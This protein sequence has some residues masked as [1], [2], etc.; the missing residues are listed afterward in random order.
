MI[1]DLIP[2]TDQLLKWIGSAFAWLVSV[3]DRFPPAET[4]MKYTY[5]FHAGTDF[6]LC[7]ASLWLTFYTARARRRNIAVISAIFFVNGMIMVLLS[8]GAGTS[9]Y[10]PISQS[11]PYIANLRNFEW[12]LKMIAVATTVKLVRVAMRTGRAE[13]NV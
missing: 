13:A 4:V 7:L 1:D 8:M 10:I 9:P 5:P 6:V 2:Y 12:L 11:R 3:Y